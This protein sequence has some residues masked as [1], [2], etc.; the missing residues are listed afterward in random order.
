MQVIEQIRGRWHYVSL[1]NGHRGLIGTR[2]MCT[3][4]G[5]GEGWIEH[6]SDGHVFNDSFR[7]CL[8]AHEIRCSLLIPEEMLLIWDQ[9]CA[10]IADKDAQ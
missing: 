10:V 9:S 6:D 2:Y 5:Q 7:I 8:I 3:N 4:G 1:M